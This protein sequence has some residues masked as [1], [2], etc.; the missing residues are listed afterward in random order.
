MTL[1]HLEAFRLVMSTG[2]MTEASRVLHTSQPQISRLIAQL[3]AIAGFT[4]FDRSGTRLS[5]SLD[6][7]RFFR[8]V[9]KA[10]AGLQ[11]LEAAA[12]NIRTFG[13]ERLAVAAMAR[14]AGGLL[15]QAVVRF[16]AAYPQ[17]LVTIHSG[18]A[19]TINTWVSS[20]LCELGL[21]ILYGADPPGVQVQTL[22]NMDCVVLLPRQHPLAR[23]PLVRARDLDEE[24]FVSFPRG[25]DPRERIDRVWASEGVHPRTVLE[26]D[27]G[28]SVC[29]LVAAGLGVSV[30]NPLAA[31]EEQ[32]QHDF[33]VRR[34]EPA[35]T[36]RLALLLAPD[37][38]QSRMVSAFSEFVGEV[39][40]S[41]L[42]PA[43]DQW[44]ASPGNRGR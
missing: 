23:R 7:Q 33:V 32:R 12:L 16:K 19:S 15:S 31:M 13:G 29:A 28:A 18:A 38:P 5:P 25:S 35:I 11:S 24:A 37:A 17:A 2:S 30:I 22:L 4:L 20:G 44:Q 3:E 27:L 8:D 21:A 41:T 43:L 9:E 26:S 39:I 1:K 10:F 14:I 40:E 36:V 34:L 6:G 42:R